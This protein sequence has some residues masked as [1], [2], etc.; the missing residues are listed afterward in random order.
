M[1]D[2]AST[3]PPRLGEAS[4]P[5]ADQAAEAAGWAMT[6]PSSSRRNGAQVVSPI[7]VLPCFFKP[8]DLSPKKSDKKP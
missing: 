3:R 6:E 2:A 1:V 8:L 5:R 4:A 7:G